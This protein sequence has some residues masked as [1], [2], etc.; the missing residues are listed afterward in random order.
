MANVA[1]DIGTY[2]IKALHA[3]NGRKNE[4]LRAVEI[5]NTAGVSVPTEK[6]STAKLVETI[7][8][9]FSDHSLPRRNVRISLPES[10]VS[11]KVI[12]I[13]YLS[14][15][16][17]AS[18]IGWQA[19]QYIPIPK[20]EL[21][22]EYEVIYRP[23]KS[24]K[25][26]L[27]SVLL[28]GV[29]HEVVDSFV[30]VFTNVGIEPKFLETQTLSILRSLDF[31]TEDPITLVVHIGASTMD[32]SV[33][34]GGQFAFVLSYP[35]GGSLFT[36]AIERVL[37]LKPQQAEEYKRAYGLNKEYLEGKINKALLPVVQSFT[38]EIKK[39]M[40]YYVTQFPGESISRILL[41]G[42][43][44]QLPGLIPFIAQDLGVETLIASPFINSTGEIPQAN[45]TAFT[46][47]MGLI[48]RNE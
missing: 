31:T 36:R 27:M 38:A 39:A 21:S 15:A 41:S 34:R 43:S 14:D 8:T 2:S 32:L 9:L 40:Q 19:E 13:P 5:P 24:E 33:V 4:I 16:E 30:D 25:N 11:T 6:T 12:Q 29:K 22:L 23:P 18:A 48:L 10:M 20:E 3:K 46:V 42:G 35:N 37:G 28:I 26:S 47:C 1:I 44:A 45:H 17:L 7:D